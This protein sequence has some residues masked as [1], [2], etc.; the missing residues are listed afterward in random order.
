MVYICKRCGRVFKS[1]NSYIAHIMFG[2]E[3]TKKSS[4]YAKRK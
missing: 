1:W 2:I 3:G 4:K